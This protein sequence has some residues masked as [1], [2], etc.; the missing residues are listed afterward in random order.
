[1]GRKKTFFLFFVEFF[2]F[3]LIFISC[4]F[5]TRKAE[6]ISLEKGEILF[7]KN[8]SVCHLGGKNI[9][10]PEKNLKKETLEAN[11][12]NNISSIVYQVING[13]NGMPA[14]G[15]RLAETDIED[16]AIYILE[17]SSKDFQF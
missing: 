14:F 7:N 9:I 13:K 17:K 4:F 6:A 3:S 1:M 16:I 5:Q 12:M 8:C 10:I 11:G 15:G 2:L